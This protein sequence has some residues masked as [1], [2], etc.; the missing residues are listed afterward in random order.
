VKRLEVD[1]VIEVQLDGGVF[2]DDHRNRIMDDINLRDEETQICHDDWRDNW[3]PD[4][5]HACVDEI[6]QRSDTQERESRLLVTQLGL[7]LEAHSTST[8]V[9]GQSVPCTTKIL[10]TPCR[11]QG[12]RQ[13]GEG[14]MPYDGR[15]PVNGTARWGISSER[16]AGDGSS[17]RASVGV[18]PNSHSMIPASD[19]V[20]FS[21]G[22]LWDDE[23][24]VS[25]EEDDADA[26]ESWLAPGAKHA[27]HKHEIGESRLTPHSGPER[28]GGDQCDE[29]TQ[30]YLDWKCPRCCARKLN[31]RIPNC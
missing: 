10:Q 26:R 2:V 13:D 18:V 31:I 6:E 3:T 29:Q 25:E 24:S 19:R 12:L 20:Q 1:G 17:R 27:Q 4:T 8:V 21:I 14:T 5:M 30:P 9:H 16:E 28:E 23:M 15:E 22:S 11:T 7:E